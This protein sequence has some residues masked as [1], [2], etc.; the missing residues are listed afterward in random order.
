LRS[1]DGHVSCFEPRAD[2]AVRD[3]D[4]RYQPGGASYTDYFIGS[5]TPAW[6]ADRLADPVL[7]TRAAAADSGSC[8]YPAARG[9]TC[10][11]AQ[12]RDAGGSAWRAAVRQGWTPWVARPTD[13]LSFLRAIGFTGDRIIY[14][15]NVNASKEESAA[16]VAF[17]NAAPNDATP[18]ESTA[19]GFDWRTAGYWR[20][21]ASTMATLRR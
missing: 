3:R 6:I 15:V 5:N 17:F 8:A 1:R 20:S 16:V 19:N 21:C 13:L 14:T 18:M 7:H 10:T 9:A 4:R 2:W 12:L 11:V